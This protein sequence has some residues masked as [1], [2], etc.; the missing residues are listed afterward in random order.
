MFD[1]KILENP[2]VALHSL[3]KP[4]DANIDKVMRQICTSEGIGTRINDTKKFEIRTQ[5]GRDLRNAISTL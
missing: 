4:T 1:P 5:C 3:N 2:R